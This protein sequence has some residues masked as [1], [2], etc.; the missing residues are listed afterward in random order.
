MASEE[1]EGGRVVYKILVRSVLQSMPQ[2][3]AVRQDHG[4]LGFSDKHNPPGVPASDIWW[5][6]QMGS[7]E[8]SNQ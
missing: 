7:E 3:P 2:V 8:E 1:E 6:G 5:S 4:P